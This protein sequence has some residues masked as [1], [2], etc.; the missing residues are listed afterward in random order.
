M[1][2]ADKTQQSIPHG[3]LFRLNQGRKT[4]YYKFEIERKNEVYLFMQNVK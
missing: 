1:Y 3:T 2:N 4:T